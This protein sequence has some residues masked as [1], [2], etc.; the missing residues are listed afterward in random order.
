MRGPIHKLR[1]ADRSPHPARKGAPTSPRTRPHRGEGNSGRGH[2]RDLRH[3]FD[4]AVRAASARAD[5]WI[6]LRAAEPRPRRHLRH[7]E[8]HQ[9][10]PWRPV[11][12]GRLRGLP[13]AGQARHRLLAGA[14]AGADHR[15]RLRHRDRAAAAAMALQARPP[16]RAAADLRSRAGHR[17]RVPPLLRRVRA[18]PTGCRI[19]CRAGRI[20]ASCSCPT[21]APG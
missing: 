7:A 1:L 8:H 15:R 13:A 5:Q 21:T 4:G 10:R 6:V 14:G 11:H 2:V 12:D 9:L 20:S 18:C 3:S 19:R 17:G 16:L